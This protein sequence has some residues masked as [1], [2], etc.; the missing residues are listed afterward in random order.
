MDQQNQPQQPINNEGSPT[1]PVSPGPIPPAGPV[2]GPAPASNPMQPAA[3]GQAP[4]GNKSFLVAWL[5]SYFVGF[6]GIDRFYLGY[7][8][9]GI[10][11][12]VTLGGCFIWALI[13]WILIWAGV[14]KA[15]DGSALQ[16]RQENLKTVLI[17]F[18]ALTALGL[19]GNII[20]AVGGN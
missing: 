19:I 16:G 10:L 11:K 5:L 12:L 18:I 1:P 9:L 20:S 6:L 14:L 2:P 7:T 13:D 4:E 8:G 17:I 3:A 15:A